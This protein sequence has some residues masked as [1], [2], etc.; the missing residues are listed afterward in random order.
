MSLKVSGQTAVTAKWC[1]SYTG[2]WI[3]SSVKKTT[4]IIYIIKNGADN[5]RVLAQDISKLKI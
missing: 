5:K 4:E 3:L 2:S 1:K